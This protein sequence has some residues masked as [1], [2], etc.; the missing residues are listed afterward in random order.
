[1]SAPDEAS[2]TP[3]T[4]EAALFAARLLAALLLLLVLIT[5]CGGGGDDDEQP[6]VPT[7]AVDCKT[8]PETCA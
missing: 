1:M 2:S 4:A 5:G 7:P 6:D 8:Q 3:H